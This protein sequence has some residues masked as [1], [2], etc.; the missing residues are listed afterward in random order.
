MKKTLQTIAMALFISGSLFAQE[1]HNAV[2]PCATYEAM[3]QA[4]QQDANARVRYEQEQEKLRQATISYEESLKNKKMGA[5]FQYT[6]PVVFHILHT[7]GAE[8]IPDANCIAALANINND[9]AATGGD[10]GTISPLFASLYV[11]AD[12]KFMLARKDPNGNCTS[13]INHYYNTSTDWNQSAPNYAYSGTGAGKWNPTR[14]LNIYVVRSICPSTSTCSSAGGV[15]IGYTYKP[16]TW[17][18]GAAQDA[19]VIRSSWVSSN[20]I[21]SRTLSH[22]IGHWLNLSHTFGN[23]NNPGVTCGDDG[24]ADTPMTKGYFSTCPS[25]STG[26]TCVGSGQANVENIMDYSSCPKMFTQGQVN[27]MRTTLASGTSGRNNLWTTTNLTTNTDVNG[28]GICAPIA[29]CHSVFGTATNV[30]TVCSGGTLTFIDDSYNGA[31]TS[32]TWTA[33]GGGVVANPS[34]ASTSI[35]FPTV[36]SQTVTL[37]VS[38]AQGSSSV[39]KVVSVISGVANYA[40][41]YQE[42]FEATG[43]PTNWAIINQTGGTTWQQYFGAAASGNNSYYMNNSINPN[44]AVDIL[45]TPSYN[46]AANPGATFT[47]K[48]AYAMYNSSWTDVFKIQASSNCGGS[49]SDIYTPTPGTMASGSGGVTSSPFIPTSTQFKLY[50]LTSH[51]AFNT[52]KTQPN[53]KI[54]FY[55]KEDAASGFG[56]NIYLDDINFNAPLGV[57]ELTQSIGLTVYPNPTSGSTNIEF[58]LNDNSNIKYSV[59]DVTGRMVEQEKS[60]DLNPGFHKFTVNENQKLSQG[61]YMINIELNGQKMS[62]KLIIE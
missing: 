62:R 56:N 60:L 45:E 59:T 19:F 38:N 12:I 30:Y 18:S 9:F 36:G 33:S 44:N 31:V 39:S 22:E 40:A 11:N 27:V 16:G 3:E 48:Y 49:W 32:R 35:T 34:N 2:M 41:T 13:G 5:A 37:T 29:D 57:N 28:S 1:P 55:F 20:V 6:I 17:L 53:V 15:I 42:S 8:N 14:Y 7:N 26:N 25:S 21:D 50:T 54:R 24:I 61:I 46:F 51:P 10:V 43:L 47:F 23:T 4:F 52:F 58:T